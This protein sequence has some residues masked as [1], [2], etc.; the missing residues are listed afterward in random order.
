MLAI[1]ESSALLG[2]DAYIVRA[3]TDISS[4]I[5]MFASVGLPDAAVQESRERVRSA[6]RNTGLDFRLRRGTFNLAPRRYPKARPGFD[7]AIAIGILAAVEQVLMPHRA[8]GAFVCELALA[9][10]GT[11]AMTPCLLSP[12][13]KTHGTRDYHRRVGGKYSAISSS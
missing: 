2:I 5:P 9:G 11:N 8:D 12:G 3:E 4:T 1:V 10:G 6:V 7:L 13:K